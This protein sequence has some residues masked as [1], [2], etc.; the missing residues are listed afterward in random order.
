MILYSIVPAELV[1]R[2]NNYLEEDKLR[3]AYYNGER[4][5]VA[6]MSDRQYEIRKLLS[7]NPRSFLN[8]AFQP[9][10]TVDVSLLKMLDN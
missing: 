5:I 3:E 6:Q 1:F 9:G 4:I 10:N 8:P 2:G 7:T